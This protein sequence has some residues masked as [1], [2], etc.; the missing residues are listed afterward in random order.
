MEFNYDPE[1]IA[2]YLESES[3]PLP[4][5]LV[6]PEEILEWMQGKSDELQSV[7]VTHEEAGFTYDLERMKEV[8]GSTAVR[9]PRG[10]ASPDEFLAWLDSLP[11]EAGYDLARMREHVESETVCL[12]KPEGDRRPG[13]IKAWLLS[14]GAGGQQGEKEAGNATT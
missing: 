14:Q 5:E 7:Q 11:N 8:V 6:Q 3:I 12:P 4:R 9:V 2:P 10:M 13:D 1:Q